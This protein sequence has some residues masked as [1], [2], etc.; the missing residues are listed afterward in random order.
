MGEHDGHDNDSVLALEQ[1]LTLQ[2]PYT[3][4]PGGYGGVLTDMALAAG[5]VYVATVDLPFKETSAKTVAPLPENSGA[6]E[7]EALSLATR[8]VGQ[9]EGAADAARRRNDLQ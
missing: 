5:T 6:G 8:K 9:H 1:Q 2:A 7:I 3:Y 4:E